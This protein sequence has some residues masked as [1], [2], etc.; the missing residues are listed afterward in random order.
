MKPSPIRRASMF[1]V[2]AALLLCGSAKA[3]TPAVAP[4]YHP[5]DTIKISVTFEGPDAGKISTAQINLHVPSP[6]PNQLGFK[7][8]IFPGESKS[9]GPNTFEISYKIPEDQ[10]SGD[11][12]LG[13]IRA[14]LYPESPITLT[15]TPAEFTAKTFKIVNPKTLVKPKIK[16]VKVL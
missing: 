14:I 16:D 7:T 12:A 2:L 1:M 6:L 10:A 9:T 8:E 13:E 3:Q 15:Y 11:Y 4:E 5:G